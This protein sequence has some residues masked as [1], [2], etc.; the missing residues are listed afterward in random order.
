[1]RGGFSIGVWDA[2]A[3]LWSRDGYGLVGLKMVAFSRMGRENYIA[4]GD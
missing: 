4:G 1:M 2:W 3:H